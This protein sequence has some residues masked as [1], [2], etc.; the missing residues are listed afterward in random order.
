[1]IEFLA[2]ASFVSLIAAWLVAPKD[3][4]AEPVVSSTLPVAEAK[5]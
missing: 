3:G 4:L 5:A 2:F 1:M